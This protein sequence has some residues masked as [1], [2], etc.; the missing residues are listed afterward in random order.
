MDILVG[1]LSEPY[2]IDSL[3]KIVFI[4]FCVQYNDGTKIYSNRKKNLIQIF[5]N[6]LSIKL[7]SH[8]SDLQVILEQI[9]ILDSSGWILI[10]DDGKIHVKSAADFNQL[11]SGN[12]FLN[13]FIGK[14]NNP[15]IAV[16]KLEDKAFLEEVIRYF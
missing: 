9:Y 14:K 3:S 1:L 11:H 10:S 5:M 13:H 2:N 8:I 7:L 12:E 6:A 16:N 4:A 15:I